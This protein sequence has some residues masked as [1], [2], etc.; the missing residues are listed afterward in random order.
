MTSQDALFESF[1]NVPHAVLGTSLQP[2]CL[3]HLLWLHQFNSPLVETSRPTTLQDLELAVQ[4]CRSTT[5]EETI[6][7][8]QIMRMPLVKRLRH[9][10]W[11]KANGKLDLKAEVVKWV[12]YYDDHLRLPQFYDSKK[13]SDLKLP[14]LLL[15]A[16]ALIKSTGWNEEQVWGMP[17]GQ[18]IFYNLAFG[19]L[20][21]GESNII[22]DKELLAQKALMELAG[23][24]N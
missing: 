13:E 21:T 7:S 22:S 16:S 5:H 2:L 3:R 18:V 20:N 19:Y 17:I 23:G 8:L 1:V 14:W 12:S 15:H 11:R 9:H 6:A 4:I 10:F 24:N